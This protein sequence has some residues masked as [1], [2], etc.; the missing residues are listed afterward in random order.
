MSA[1]THCS[2][3]DVQPR[4]IAASIA[5]AGVS[6]PV[7]VAVTDPVRVSVDEAGIGHVRAQLDQPGVARRQ[8]RLDVGASAQGRDAAV[9][10]QDR[11][12]LGRLGH[13]HDP[14]DEH[15][16]ARELGEVAGDVAGCGAAVTGDSALPVG[17]GSTDTG[18][19]QAAAAKARA[20][21]ARSAIETVLLDLVVPAR[22]G[23]PRIWGE[24]S[25]HNVQSWMPGRAT[26]AP[27]ASV[28]EV[29]ATDRARRC[30]PRAALEPIRADDGLGSGVHDLLE[31]RRAGW[32]PA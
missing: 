13:R 15:D 17:V 11:L 20:S 29:S 21:S 1:S 2:L 32:P 8:V 23:P 30:R 9:D 18:A 7:V 24:T 14:S 27:P 12:D 26:R 10:D 6:M 28:L 25:D 31:K 4:R 16:A 3:I 19:A 22:A 5:S